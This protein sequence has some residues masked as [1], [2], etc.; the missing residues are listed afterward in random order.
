M[1][2]YVESP[3]YIWILLSLWCLRL[4]NWAKESERWGCGIWVFVELWFWIWFDFSKVVI[5]FND[6]WRNVFCDIGVW[7]DGREGYC[8]EEFNGFWGLE[9]GRVSVG[10]HICYGWKTGKWF[11]GIMVKAWVLFEGV[12]MKDL[13]Q[14]LNAIGSY[15]WNIL[16]IILIHDVGPGVM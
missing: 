9:N 14:Y 11:L 16:E 13:S 12:A 10:Q 1:W 7:W 6:E 4:F 8:L 2:K 5:I 3:S 15:A